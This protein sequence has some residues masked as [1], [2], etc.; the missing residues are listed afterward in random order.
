MLNRQISIARA[1][2]HFGGMK[3]DYFK[4]CLSR[5]K[6]SSVLTGPQLVQLNTFMQSTFTIDW[7]RELRS[8]YFWPVAKQL[9]LREVYQL[10][11]ILTRK[12]A[13]NS[14]ASSN[15][16]SIRSCDQQAPD[17]FWT[18]FEDLHQIQL[19]NESAVDEK[20]W[21]EDFEQYLFDKK[22]DCEKVGESLAWYRVSVR[23]SRRNY[24]P[25]IRSN[26]L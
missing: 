7:M 21:S 25:S 6:S 9:F 1:S 8:L 4:Y 15:I 22:I 11:G 23:C 12:R 16:G 18:A 5:A 3:L 14:G 24:G 2:K 13:M 10:T 17:T 26:F 19:D 20:H